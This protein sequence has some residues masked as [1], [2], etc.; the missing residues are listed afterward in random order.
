MLKFFRKYNKIILAVFGTVLM[1]VFLLPEAINQIS[2]PTGRTVATL[3]GDDISAREM[4]EY[5]RELAILQSLSP[6]GIRIGQREVPLI[7]A[8]LG[9]EDEEHWLL[10]RT[11]A[12]RAGYVGGPQDGRNFLASL[13]ELGVEAQIQSALA[14]ADPAIRGLIARQYTPEVRRQLEQQTLAA[15]D[16]ARGRLVGRYGD[17]D[18][19][20]MALAR[21][22]GVRRL[23]EAYLDSA[24]L[25]GLEAVALA[26]QDFDQTIINMVRVP[27]ARLLDQVEEPTEE[28]IEAHFEEYKD[29]RPG[30]GEHGFGFLR[31]AAAAIEWLTIDRTA[32]RDSVNPDPV[33]A[34]SRYQRQREGAYAEREFSEVRDQIFAAMRRGRAEEIVEEATQRIRAELLKA[35]GNLPS[36]DGFKVLPEDWEQRRPVL[37]NVARTVNADLRGRHDMDADPVIA[38]R[39]GAML[40]AAAMLNLTY[41]GQASLN[42]A[43]QT[44]PLPALVFSVRELDE[45]ARFGVQVGLTY[46]R[47]VVDPSGRLHFFRVVRVRPESPPDTLQSVRGQVI[48]DLERLAAYELLKEQSREYIDLAAGPNG[49]QRIADQVGGTVEEQVI[50]RESGMQYEEQGGA[51]PRDVNNEAVRSAIMDRAA[52]LDPRLDVLALEDPT[53]AVVAVPV[54]E[55]LHLVV[56]RIVSNEPIALENFRRLAPLVRVPV[57]RIGSPVAPDSAY[58]KARLAERLSFESLREDPDETPVEEATPGQEGQAPDEGEAPGDAAESAEGA[59]AGE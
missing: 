11:L 17:E 51:P 26:R 49:I 52:A 50:V 16:E 59:S 2:A 53:E 25:Y 10:L 19:I 37:E 57:Q 34:Y 14:M 12:E 31:D 20:N 5:G 8:E 21:A 13:A 4:E 39:S 24:E 30:M 6:V 18:L 32:I 38:T 33:E 58:T 48:R 46:D 44:I 9:V 35:S 28:Q 22:A 55:A 42:Y 27:P 1:V 45:N 41:I 3:A 15:L 7:L 54:P 43:G 23:Y 56:A 47:P 29:V 36:E 40:T